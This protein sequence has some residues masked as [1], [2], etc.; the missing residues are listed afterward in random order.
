MSRYS[1][2]DISNGTVRISQRSGIGTMLVGRSA[3][4]QAERVGVY[5]TMLADGSL[6]Y[7]L[8]VVP[9]DDASVYDPTFDRVGT[10]IRLS[11]R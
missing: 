11:D 3:L 5:T 8:T 9:E 7:Y 1:T 2:R 6:F 4:N 10:S